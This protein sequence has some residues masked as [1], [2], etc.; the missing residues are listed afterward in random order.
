MSLNIKDAEAHKLAQT[1]AR[2]TGQ[3]M[4]KAVTEALRDQLDRV[5]RRRKSSRRVDEALAIGRR[6]AK[7]L[8][9]TPVD[10][11]KLLYDERGLPK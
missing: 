3:S 1:L 7:M 10:H 11:D 4:T 8:K 6:C 5:R 2:E 9:G